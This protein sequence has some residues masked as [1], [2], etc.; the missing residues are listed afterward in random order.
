VPNHKS[1]CTMTGSC[2]GS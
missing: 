1:C 2:H